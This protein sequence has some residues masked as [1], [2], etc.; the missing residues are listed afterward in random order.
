[1]R[2]YLLGVVLNGA[3]SPPVV[4]VLETRGGRDPLRGNYS[5]R[6]DANQ[7][8]QAIKGPAKLSFRSISKGVYPGTCAWGRDKG[9][10][11][12][13]IHLDYKAFLLAKF[14]RPNALCFLLGQAGITEGLVLKMCDIVQSKFWVRE[15]RAS[16]STS[17]SPVHL[18]ARRLGFK[19]AWIRLHFIPEIMKTVPCCQ[20][21]RCTL[22][23]FLVSYSSSGKALQQ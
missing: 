13:S 6:K 7:H 1:M 18:C 12:G 15:P 3:I 10:M 8:S 20:R 22:R 9:T 23:C 5:N 2:I 4:K 14:R 16:A 17:R 21:C 11:R 19:T